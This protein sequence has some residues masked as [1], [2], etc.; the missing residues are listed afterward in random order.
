MEAAFPFRGLGQRPQLGRFNEEE[1]E[2][3]RRWRTAFANFLAEF[4]MVLF[5]SDEEEEGN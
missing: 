3:Y 4:Y 1:Y 2:I 5:G